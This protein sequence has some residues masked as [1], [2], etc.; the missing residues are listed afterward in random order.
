MFNYLI[1]NSDAHAK[2][3]SVM[4]NNQAY[5]L[6]PFYDLMCV[7]A[8]GDHDLALFIGDESTYETV[9]VHSWKAFCHDC[10]FA[11]KPT[12]ALFRK[13]AKD[14]RRCWDKTVS[15]AIRQYPL[16]SAERALI[17]RI[18][19]IIDANSRAASSMSQP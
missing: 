15:T 17:E 10:G 8:Y 4:V 1:G 19:A 12:M 11:F 7:Q 18:G 3:I 16:T 5:G 2:N 9:G 13:M 14:V 6:A